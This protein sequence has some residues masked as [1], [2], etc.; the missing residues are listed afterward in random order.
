MNEYPTSDKEIVFTEVAP[1][2]FGLT[3]QEL[4]TIDG[5]VAIAKHSL[6][7]KIHLWAN[8]NYDIRQIDV[9]RFVTERVRLNTEIDDFEVDY[10]VLPE[11]IEGATKAELRALY[12]YCV[13]NYIDQIPRE[14]KLFMADAGALPNIRSERIEA[15][16]LAFCR[17]VQNVITWAS[18]KTWKTQTERDHETDL[19][20][21]EKDEAE[22]A[23]RLAE[24][25]FGQD[26]STEALDELKRTK[27]NFES[28]GR[29]IIVD[30]A[31]DAAR[32]A[33]RELGVDDSLPYDSKKFSKYMKRQQNAA[34]R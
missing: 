8:A 5:A 25:L 2:P 34:G 22:Q 21:R 11:A 31:F 3:A 14:L 4:G 19:R 13:Y 20:R 15:R 32:Q 12:R 16:E 7:D 33:L 10:L 27:H 24:R 30:C 26:G 28:A 17:A 29:I 18:L 9:S 23:L 1:N 6:K